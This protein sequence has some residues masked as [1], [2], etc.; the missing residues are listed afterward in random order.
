MRRAA[1]FLSI[2]ALAAPL[3]AAA[4]KL[5]LEEMEVTRWV[6]AHSTEAEALLE[7][8]VD[9]N[10]GTMNFAGVRSVGAALRTE[11]DSL[12]FETQWIDVPETNRAGHLFAKRPG[13][14]GKKLLLIGHLD[15]V[16]EE[17]DPF[18][19]FQRQSNGWASGPGVDDMKSGDVVIVFALKALAAAGLLDVPRSS[20][21][22]PATRKAPGTRWT[23][24]GGIWSRR[25]SGPMSL[26]ASRT[27]YATTR[28]SGRPS[29]DAAPV[30]GTWK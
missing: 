6:D 12:G 17:D 18:Q 20:W 5:S 23:R 30:D 29:H 19:R 3:G 1:S 8:L 4:Q 11:L 13:T 15:T 27:E 7:R 16:F 10:S 9:I 28:L 25:A 2:I 21:R 26:S 24:Q 22:T 14:R